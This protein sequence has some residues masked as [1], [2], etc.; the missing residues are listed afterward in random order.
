MTQL[1]WQQ[2]EQ[3]IL[4]LSAAEKQRL[5]NLLNQ[6]LA[7]QS[8]RLDPLLGLMADEP[9][10]VDSVMDAAFAARERDTVQN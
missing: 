7:S 8:T 4:S 10:L 9:D 2:L 6:S 5:R 1:E 3:T